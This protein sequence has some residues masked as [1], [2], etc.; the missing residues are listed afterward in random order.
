[1]GSVESKGRLKKRS[2]GTIAKLN[3]ESLAK[4][5]EILRRNE[6]VA[7]PTET[8]YG[9]AGRA[10]EPDALVKIFETKERPRFDPLIVHLAPGLT[11]NPQNSDFWLKSLEDLG[12][13]DLSA[14][15]PMAL[16]RLSLLASRFWPGP[17]TLLFRKTSRIPDLATSGLPDV[18]LRMPKHPT[19]LALIEALGEPLAAP[20]ANRF[21]KISPTCAEHVSEELGDRIELILD[22]GSCS[23]GVES[24]VLKV[25]DDGSGQI[26]RPGGVSAEELKQLVDEDF[27]VEK[28][29]PSSSSMAPGMLK[30]HYAPAKPLTLTPLSFSS[31]RDS[32]LLHFDLGASKSVGVLAFSG[33]QQK[34]RVRLEALWG[35]KVE[36]EVLSETG[37][38]AEAA[39]TLFSKLRRLDHSLVETLVAESMP[40]NL[41]LASAI[42]DRLNRASSR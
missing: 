41:G 18:A 38:L 7:M 30:S 16:S 31:V 15:S 21:G 17:L 5:L 33:N 28:P 19:A 37:D 29:T 3:P 34:I 14:Y 39:R 27:L 32:E 36:V 20:S 4:A 1:L 24:T 22:G 11:G 12:W 10:L 26:L 23:V 6:V 13:I 25:F 42:Q 35:V 9:L 2:L 40:K 8:V